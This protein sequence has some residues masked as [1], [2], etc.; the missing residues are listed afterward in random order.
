MG[1]VIRQGFSGQL[2][3]VSCP[4]MFSIHYTKQHYKNGDTASS[5]E[6]RKAKCSVREYLKTDLSLSSYLNV[7][8]LVAIKICHVD[9]DMCTIPFLVDL[10]P[11]SFYPSPRPKSLQGAEPRLSCVAVLSAS[12]MPVCTVLSAD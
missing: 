12:S 7:F 5:P 2:A 9:Q 1:Q 8:N 4:L 10:W 6:I 11:L 3:F